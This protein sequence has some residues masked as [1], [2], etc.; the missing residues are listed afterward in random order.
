MRMAVPGVP[1]DHRLLDARFGGIPSRFGDRLL[2]MS[3]RNGPIR[4]D[5]ASA[6]A[7]IAIATLDH[8]RGNRV[9]KPPCVS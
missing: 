4:R 3:I 5:A 9:A 2:E 1:V 8:R 7:A 6:S